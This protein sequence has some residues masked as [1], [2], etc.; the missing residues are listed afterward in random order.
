MSGGEEIIA[1]PLLCT[2]NTAEVDQPHVLNGK[3][4][5]YFVSHVS[6]Y[7]YP[8][9][10]HALGHLLF[11]SL[12]PL[13]LAGLLTCSAKFAWKKHYCKQGSQSP[14]QGKHTIAIPHDTSQRYF[15]LD[16]CMVFAI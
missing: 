15:R 5:M 8:S 6:C 3:E 12:L 4:S 10:S 2:W 11:A 14:D 9:F 1:T 7:S 16:A 13:H